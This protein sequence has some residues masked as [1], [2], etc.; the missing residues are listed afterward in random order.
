MANM[1]PLAKHK[2]RSDFSTAFFNV[3]AIDTLFNT[4]FNSPD[5]AADAALASGEKAVVI[6]GTDDDYMD[7]VVPV[8]EKIKAANPGICVMVAGFSP[9][10]V[11][12][13][14]AA[15]V[16]EFIH[17]RADVLDI[18]GKLQRRLMGDAYPSENSADAA[19]GGKK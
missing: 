8:T 6:C 10:Y 11:D 12:L 2:P 7:V 9:K 15:G 19:K 14:K 18:L 16:D 13:F 1:G 4:G 5:E 3:A 17:L